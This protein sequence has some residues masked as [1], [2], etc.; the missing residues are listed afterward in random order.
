MPALVLTIEQQPADGRHVMRDDERDGLVEEPEQIRRLRDLRRNG[1]QH[2]GAP[3]GTETFNDGATA[4]GMSTAADVR[5]TGLDRWGSSRDVGQGATQ[6]TLT[7]SR[8]NA[9][10]G[11]ELGGN[12][13]IWTFTGRAR[14]PF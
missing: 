9:I 1:G 11:A 5:G 10:F 12:T 7:A 4:L 3:T 6:A 2:G 14:I 13:Q 8:S